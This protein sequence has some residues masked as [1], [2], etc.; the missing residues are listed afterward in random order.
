MPLSKQHPIRFCPSC[1]EKRR[2][3][4]N[5]CHACGFGIAESGGGGRASA[6]ML[7]AIALAMTVVAFAA[8]KLIDWDRPAPARPDAV[9]EDPH[10]GEANAELE[11]LK[12]RA[13]GGDPNALMELAERQIMLTARDEDYL[14]QAAQ[15]LEKIIDRFPEHG[16]ALRLAGNVYFQLAMPP[17]AIDYYKRYLEIYPQD[18]NVRVDLGT[19]LLEVERF[20]E[21]IDQYEAAIRLFP[22]FYNAYHN[23]AVAYGRMNQPERAAE[24]RRKAEEIEKTHGRNLAPAIEMPRMPTLASATPPAAAEEGPFAALESFFRNHPVVGPKVA[25]FK[26]EGVKAT[27]LVRNFPMSVMPEPMLN[28]F[29]AKVQNQLNA[30]ELEAATLEIR[31]ADSSEVMASYEKGS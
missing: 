3:G 25:G 14:Y 31:D 12:A 24:N 21:A 23:L 1:G 22:N 7:A 9:A 10:A 18:A 13:D 4:A 20:Q 26:A 11:A 19:Q 5:F 16:Y 6:I 2:E 8:V 27:L 30:V 29:E 15:T 17:K 28:S